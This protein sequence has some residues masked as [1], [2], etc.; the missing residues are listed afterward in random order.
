MSYSVLGCRQVLK[1]LLD[2]QEMMKFSDLYYIHNDLFINDYC[3][4]IQSVK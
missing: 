4:W 1:C 2:V 3:V